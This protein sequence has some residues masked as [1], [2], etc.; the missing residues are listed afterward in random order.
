MEAS[1]LNWMIFIPTIGALACLLLPSKEQA[2]QTALLTSIVTLV[3]S[4]YLTVRYYHS[5]FSGVA[6]ESEVSWIGGIN[7]FYRTG[8]DGLSLPLVLLTSALSVLIVLASWKIEKATKA[9]LALYLFLMT[10][11][12]GVFLALDLFLFYVFFEVSL[13]PMYFLIGV[14]GGPRKEYAAIKFFLF[15]L[16]GSICLLIVM[17]GLY[18]LTPKIDAAQKKNVWAMVSS[19]DVLTLQSKPVRE[20][21]SRPAPTRVDLPGAGGIEWTRQTIPEASTSIGTALDD[22]TSARNIAMALSPA[23]GR[24]SIREE[25]ENDMARELEAAAAH[26]RDQL[27]ALQDDASKKRTSAGVDYERAMAVAEGD[28]ELVKEAETDHKKALAR[29]AEN[30]SG[31]RAATADSFHAEISAILRDASSQGNVPWTFCLWAFW[32]TFIAFAIKVPVAPLH[33]WLP[34]AHVEA[35]TPISM[36]LAG[37]LLKMGGYALMRITYP[38]FPD[39]A[40][41][42]W[43]VVASI[44]VFSI[45]YGAL[46]SLAQSDWK[47]LVAY[48]SVSHMGYVILGIAV[49]TRTGFDGAY[50]QM[51]AHG[52][53]SAMM[54]FLVGVAYER[55]H[56]R[57]IDRFGGLWLKW[58]GYG[59]WSL[60]GFFAAMG[61]PGMCGFIG[62]IMVL[63]GTFQAAAPGMVGHTQT[64]TVYTFGILA[65]SGVILTAAYI[66]WMFQRI[67]MGQQRP[68]YTDYEA[69]QPREF[70]IMG[71]LGV[72]AIVLGI[73][74]YLVFSMTM[75]TFEQLMKMFQTGVTVMI[76]L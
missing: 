75:P 47:K 42:C 15:T 50:F 48:S 31:R 1:L 9:Y 18:F 51:I 17:L 35:P 36:I 59:G 53:T 26:H 62:E 60:L 3:I 54:F 68:E 8:V 61:L 72:A 49:L 71:T 73:V 40:V 76:G 12:Y 16:A 37:V 56:H 39:A 74:P 6:F 14:W 30:E 66:L 7:A 45:I 24:G 34:D 38:F 28:A 13:L 67:Y 52:I 44:G 46:C 21:F 69:V 41:T 20:F 4:V 5:D 58:P 2:K 32:L 10:G 33:T 19:R 43:V 57:Q 65:A 23:M 55:S 70:V 25:L 29:L 64:A 11:M 63:L 22:G 27:T